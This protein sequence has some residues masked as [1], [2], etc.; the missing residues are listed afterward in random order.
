MTVRTLSLKTTP[1][2]PS[3]LKGALRQ[4]DLGLLRRED[5]PLRP[6]ERRFLTPFHTL[7]WSDQKR[8]GLSEEVTGRGSMVVTPQGEGQLVGLRV[9]GEP[10][11][12]W[13]PTQFDDLCEWLD[14]VN[15][16]QQGRLSRLDGVLRAAGFDVRSLPL[17]CIA[18]LLCGILLLATAQLASLFFPLLLLAWMPGL[19]LLVLGGALTYGAW[20]LLPDLIRS[21]PELIVAACM[22]VGRRVR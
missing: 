20:C 21:I 18:M 9:S 22:P 7:T 11:I 1:T 15:L 3:A 5:L 4:G 6:I 17:L 12:A 2:M 14:A 19:P 16:E 13:D 10:V 8:L